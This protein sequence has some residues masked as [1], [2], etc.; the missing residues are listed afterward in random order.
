MDDAA[1]TLSDV[2]AEIDLSLLSG[3][4]ATFIAEMNRAWRADPKSVDQN[5]NA[6][7]EAFGD[8]AHGGDEAES[9]PSWGRAPSR[10]VGAIDPDASI[11]AVAEGH[12]SGR[13]MNATDMRA[14][15][16]DSLRAV[17]LIRAYRIR[18]HLIADLDPL[19]LEDKP[20]HPE[21]DP[22]SYGFGDV[23][24][25]RPIFID[26]VLGLETATLSEII[27]RLRKTYCGTI[28]VE[29]MHIQDPAQ[30]AWIQERIE[31]I[32]NQ[33]DFTVKGKKAIYERLVDAEEFERYL[34]KKY[35]GTKRFGMDGAEAVIPALEQI[36][37]R[38]SQLDLRE[39]VIGMAHRGR[40]NVLHNVLQKPFRAIISE[41][42]GNPANPEN[43]G[44]SG[45]VK[46]H[47]GAS[48]DRDFDDAG[49]HL[50]LA[51]NPSHL[52]IVDPVVVGRVRA[53][54]Q[55]RGDHDRTQVLGILLHGDAAFAGQGV[56]AETFAFSA[57]RGYRTGGTI[58]IIINNQIGFT[59]SPSFSRSSPY[60]TDVAKMVMA[61]IFHVNGDDPEAVVHVARIATEFRQAFGT[62][63]VIDMFCYR[64]FG[65]NEG[66]EPAFTQPLMYNA[67]GAHLSTRDLYAQRLVDEG[68]YDQEAAQ[69][70]VADRIAY[71]D[72]EFD[73]G[74]NYLPNKADWLEGSWSG[75]VA[76]HG[77]DRRGETAIELDKLRQIGASMTT[78]PDGMT[79]NSKL[80]RIIKA[81]GDMI[82]KGSGIDW[83]TA[84]HLAFGSI[85]M[86]GNPVR[87]SGQDSCRG[88]FSQRHAVFVDQANEERYTPLNHLSDDQADF[89]VIDSPLSEAS[90]M[91]FEY[92]FSQVEP[93]ALVM[94]EAQFG[95][96]AN[97]AQVVVDQFISSGE[98]KWL[99]MNAL[100]LL[101]PHGY[102]GQGPEHSSAR[103][104]RYLQLCAEDNMQVVNCTTPANY[105]HALRRQLRRNFRKPLIVM[106]PKSLLRHK[107]CVSDLADM[108][109]G[110]TF[111]RLLDE[112]DTQVRHGKVKRIVLCSGKVYYDLAAAR[113]AAKA[114]DIEILRV[115]QL[116]PFPIKAVKEILSRT[117]KASVAWCQ[118]EP[119]NMGGWTFVRDYI[120]DIMAE[121]GMQQQRLV[122]AGRDAAASPATGTLS[123]HNRE[124]NHLVAAALDLPSQ[125][126][127]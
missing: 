70:V 48:A 101:L 71:L 36:L 23:D 17:M 99:R 14:A 38:G 97:G 25:D 66:D 124:Q 20:L 24:W 116:Y 50:S 112:R 76:A 29:F 19:S 103:L 34:H 115:E 22:K 47:M 95:D 83:S 37:K 11:K 121:T 2:S 126:K 125:S 119:K 108:G 7:F 80:L 57:L 30:K 12:V 53:K 81:R 6:Y 16:L 10:V 32:G 4:N 74:T 122:Y 60:P 43:A 59:T 28:G 75:M 79:L 5:W 63:A 8:L 52:E 13:T 109:P 78:P 21:L 100:V 82:A 113:D 73:A 62:D 88:T 77:E 39:A 89:E 26:H 35:T 102:E 33:T 72:A 61:P 118:E 96:F 91:G 123:R 27:D 105:F 56:V 104:E 41:F 18:G 9:G 90:V 117:P 68:I 98:A 64:R 1:S 67:I 85:L 46:Y 87:L 86:E 114:W 45:D 92:G 120:E 3:A 111:H 110:T 49:V 65:H 94:W 106:T 69:Q 54:Q 15:T 107:A 44:G 58:H 127:K 84:E 51:P 31:A 55:Q 42:L 40:L 93:N